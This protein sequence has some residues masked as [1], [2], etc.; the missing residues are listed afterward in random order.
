MNGG[1]LHAVECLSA[2]ELAEAESSYRFFSLGA[3]SDLLFRA[4]KILEADQEIESYERLL[5]QE[6]ATLIPD[7]SALY[8]QFLHVYTTRSAEFAGVRDWNG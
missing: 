8:Q 5:D 7:D 4:R 3:V 2:L 1:V 6:Y